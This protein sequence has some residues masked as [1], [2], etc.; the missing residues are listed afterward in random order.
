MKQIFKIIKPISKNQYHWI[1][2]DI[3]VGTLIKMVDDVYRVMN[4]ALGILAEIPN[5]K[6]NFG[7][8]FGHI[9]PIHE[10][11]KTII[12]LYYFLKNHLQKAK[13]LL[14]LKQIVL[15]IN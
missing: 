1:D 11:K 6:G 4:P 15:I 12:R 13:I 8:P 14:K 10:Y 7:I 3:E 9:E 2:F 5:Q